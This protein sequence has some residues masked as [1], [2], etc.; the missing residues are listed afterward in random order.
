[1]GRNYETFFELSLDMLSVS[2]M[3]G[4]IRDVNKAWL[5]VTGW[6]K[7]EVV[8]KS[9]YEFFH[10]DDIPM[11]EKNMIGVTSGKP[12]RNVEIRYR[13]KNGHYLWL[14]CSGTPSLDTGEIFAVVQDITKQRE[15]ESELRRRETFLTTLI[16]NL[17]VALFCQDG[18]DNL[19]IVHWNKMAE[20][21]WG[22]PKRD[23]LGKPS[24]ELF[25]RF[26]ERLQEADLALLQRG[27]PVELAEEPVDSGNRG[28]IYLQTKK[29][30]VRDEVG[31]PRYLLGISEDITDRKKLEIERAKAFQQARM[32]SL[33]E[34]A[35]GIGH[36]INNPLA[37]VHGSAAHL[38]TLIEKGGAE[39]DRLVSLCEKIENTSMRIAKIVKGLRALAREGSEDPLRPV[40]VVSLVEETMELCR[41]RFAFENIKLNVS[42]IPND[43]MVDCRAAQIPQVLLNLLS[44]SYDAVVTAKER[45]VR[46]VVKDRNG[47]IEFAVEDSGAGIPVEARGRLM[48][49]F[50]TTKDAG[51]GT[52][53]GLTISKGIAE[54]HGGRL[55]ADFEAPFTRFV[56]ELPKSHGGRS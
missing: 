11:V 53:L 50:Y 4:V 32:A 25:E 34:M 37:V 45:W 44:N 15:L 9:M 42:E 35:S 26:H 30:P 22:V 17:P 38:K 3:R 13:H 23:A 8:G 14:N 49:P 5:T 31:K 27:E 10:P 21:I 40:P 51:K 7:S 52:G 29:V 41:A 43:L 39:P 36:E 2:D 18:S 20:E 1:M 48:K 28:I 33:G 54:S 46:V 55:Y 6:T 56:M 12:I 24:S 16:D 47:V 19:K